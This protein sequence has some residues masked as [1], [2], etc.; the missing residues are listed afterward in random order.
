MNYHP[1]RG[2]KGVCTPP[3]FNREEEFSDLQAQRESNTELVDDAPLLLDLNDSEP[4]VEEWRYQFP[5]LNLPPL[6]D[7][8]TEVQI[9]V[10]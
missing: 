2:W 3:I 5:D 6:V 7:R 8:R 1:D 9:V 4:A 10:P